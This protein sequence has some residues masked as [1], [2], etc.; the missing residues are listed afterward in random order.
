MGCY[1]SESKKTRSQNCIDSEVLQ[2]ICSFIAAAIWLF[3]STMPMSR[4]SV[5]SLF[6]G[7]SARVTRF[8]NKHEKEDK[9]KCVFQL[10]QQEE[11]APVQKL[12]NSTDENIHF[13]PIHVKL[14]DCFLKEKS[15]YLTK[16]KHFYG[17]HVWIIAGLK[18][19]SFPFELYMNCRLLLK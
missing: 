8:E 19:Q 11:K 4:G 1:L 15:S 18:C 17:E 2:N 3:I 16:K 10:L 6:L 9:T 5:W 7:H 13:W 12:M 14:F